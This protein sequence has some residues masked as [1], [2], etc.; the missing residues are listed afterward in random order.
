MIVLCS[1]NECLY[2]PFL[3]NA[4]VLIQTRFCVQQEKTSFY[5]CL[6]YLSAS[7][8]IPYTV[9]TSLLVG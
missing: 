3:D 5:L 7:T 9:A 6:P 2:F 4:K 1:I 8:P